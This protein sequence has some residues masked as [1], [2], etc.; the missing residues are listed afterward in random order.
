MR[1]LLLLMSMNKTALQGIYVHGLT[2][3]DV[4]T[5]ITVE[6]QVDKILENVIRSSM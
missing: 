2:G 6:Y 4:I 3:S 1:P 5:D